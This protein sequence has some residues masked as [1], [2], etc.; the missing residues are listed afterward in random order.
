MEVGTWWNFGGPQDRYH[1][2]SVV[3]WPCGKSCSC[4][5]VVHDWLKKDDFEKFVLEETVRRPREAGLSILL[6]VMDFVNGYGSN[7]AIVVNFVLQTTQ[8][9]AM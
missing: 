6:F 8:F 1:S 3:V 9:L 7:N 5:V 4:C 2:K